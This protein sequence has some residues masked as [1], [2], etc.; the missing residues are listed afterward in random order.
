MS[1]LAKG[2]RASVEIF[3][4][5]VLFGLPAARVN[6]SLHWTWHNQMCSATNSVVSSLHI[7]RRHDIF[8]FLDLFEQRLAS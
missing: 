8:L 3:L 4:A 7:F 5:A 6:G 1:E 2:V